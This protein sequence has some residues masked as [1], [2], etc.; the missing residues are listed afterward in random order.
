MVTIIACSDKLDYKHVKGFSLDCVTENEVHLSL[1]FKAYEMNGLQSADLE[2]IADNDDVS[3]DWSATDYIA[4]YNQVSFISNDR[5]PQFF[6]MNRVVLEDKS[7]S[8]KWSG[9]IGYTIENVE[10][11]QE[12]Q[13]KCDDPLYEWEGR[14]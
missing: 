11:I 5:N 3:G 8:N 10:G 7:L 9:V 2:I 13:V 1:A 14:H 12:L 4:T 6:T